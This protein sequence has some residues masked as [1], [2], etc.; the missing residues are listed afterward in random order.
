MEN[1]VV[2]PRTTTKVYNKN[3]GNPFMPKWT[4]SCWTVNELILKDPELRERSG[5]GVL[6]QSITEVYLVNPDSGRY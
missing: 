5:A 4:P 3:A 6:D 2:P 1:T